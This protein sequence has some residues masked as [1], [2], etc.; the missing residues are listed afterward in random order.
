MHKYFIMIF[1]KPFETHYNA[2]LLQIIAIVIY[3]T[4]ETSYLIP[5]EEV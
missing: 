1:D 5:E 3:F 2:S 4:G